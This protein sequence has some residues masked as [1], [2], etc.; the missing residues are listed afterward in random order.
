M[1]YINIEGKDFTIE[2]LKALIEKAENKKPLRYPNGALVELLSNGQE[3]WVPYY[4]LGNILI[5]TKKSVNYSEFGGRDGFY[6]LN[7]LAFKTKA[8]CQRY[9][10]MLEV[11]SRLYKKIGEIDESMGWNKE[12]ERWYIWYD[13]RDDRFSFDQEHSR[14]DQGKIYMSKES[15]NRLI[16]EDSVKDLKLFLS[17]LE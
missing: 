9:I 17:I 10:D 8:E 2:E 11:Q 4:H 5:P 6:Q 12:S 15:A 16:T 7:R 13:I 3:Y 14:N 1:N